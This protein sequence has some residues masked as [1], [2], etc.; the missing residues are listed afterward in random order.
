MKPAI[1]VP[2]PFAGPFLIK[3]NIPCVAVPCVELI[4]SHEISGSVIPAP[5]KKTVSFLRAGMIDALSFFIYFHSTHYR[6][7]PWLLLIETW[8]FMKSLGVRPV[9]ESSGS[10][11]MEVLTGQKMHWYTLEVNLYLGADLE[12]IRDGFV[13]TEKVL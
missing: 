13:V 6:A 12:G 10:S 2:A 11:L 5:L 4:V 7:L 3:P 9:E 8:R 1:N